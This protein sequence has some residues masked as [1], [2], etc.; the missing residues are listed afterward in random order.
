MWKYV[1]WREDESRC[2]LGKSLDAVDNILL[3]FVRDSQDQ[4]IYFAEDYIR[5]TIKPY[6]PTDEDCKYPERLKARE[7]KDDEMDI[8]PAVE[9]TL[10][11]LAKLHRCLNVCSM[12][13]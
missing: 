9:M 2:V 12:K 13:T 3:M 10:L 8:Y 6:E 5:Y 7:S 11:C 1:S 4:I